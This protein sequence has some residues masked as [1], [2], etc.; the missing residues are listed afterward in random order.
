MTYFSPQSSETA[1]GEKNQCVILAAKFV[2][3]CHTVK[4]TH[5]M[6][7]VSEGLHLY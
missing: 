5:S 4:E 2:D 3:C 1:Y 7:N 6:V